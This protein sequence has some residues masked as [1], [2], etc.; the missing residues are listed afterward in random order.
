MFKNLLTRHSFTQFY[1][2]CHFK[3]DPETL[4]TAACPLSFYVGVYRKYGHYYAKLDPLGLYN[5]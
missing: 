4:Q 1:P 3:I 2:P 5:K